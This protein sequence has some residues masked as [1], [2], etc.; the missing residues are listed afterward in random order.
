MLF[1]W[2]FSLVGIVTG[3]DVRMFTHSSREHS[4]AHPSDKMRF[5]FSNNKLKV[6]S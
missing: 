2:L 6:R 5:F 3:T 1:M 4:A